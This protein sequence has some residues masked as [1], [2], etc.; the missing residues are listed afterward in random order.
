M[1][2]E[3]NTDEIL[4]SHLKSVTKVHQFL[5]DPYQMLVD[6]T[7]GVLQN[8]TPSTGVIAVQVTGPSHQSSFTLHD[9]GSF[10]YTPVADF[11]GT[12]SFTYQTNDGSLTSNTATVTI[13]VNS[14]P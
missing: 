9:D 8:D 2:D 12:D 11:F 3:K 1:T 14:V 7:A 6:A 13:T 5:R 4:V 10:D